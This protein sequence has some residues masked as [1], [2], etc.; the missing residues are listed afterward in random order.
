MYRVSSYADL[1]APRVRQL[2]HAKCYPWKLQLLIMTEPQQVTE[3][4]A[5]GPW[6]R[7]PEHHQALL[8]PW[9]RKKEKGEEWTSRTQNATWLVDRF[10]LSLLFATLLVAFWRA[11]VTSWKWMLLKRFGSETI[12]LFAIYFYVRLFWFVC[13]CVCVFSP[14]L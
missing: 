3:G 12:Y 2:W 10:V 11:S 1:P 5:T 7:S 14:N 8:L 13:V 4:K 9:R 6:T